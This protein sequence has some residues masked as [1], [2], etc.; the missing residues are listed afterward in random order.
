MIACLN[1]RLSEDH[2]LWRV[3]KRPWHGAWPVRLQCLKPIECSEVV[4]SYYH[5]CPFAFMLI[6]SSPS[7]CPAYT[8]LLQHG[9]TFSSKDAFCFHPVPLYYCSSAW[10]S[11][12][13]ASRLEPVIPLHSPIVL[14]VYTSDVR[15]FCIYWSVC[16]HRP[17]ACQGQSSCFICLCILRSLVI[18]MVRGAWVT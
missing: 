4:S 10:I 12:Y 5:Y 2:T 3:V 16:L 14:T 13:S 6:I 8:L 7:L 15:H 18:K 17:W 1:L 9:V 11:H